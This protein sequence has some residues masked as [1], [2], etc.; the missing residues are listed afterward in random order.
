M[1][2][3]FLSNKLF[4]V[5]CPYPGFVK[6][7]KILLVGNMGLYDYRP[8]VKKVANNKQIMYDCEKGYVLAEGPPGA[9]CIGGQWSPQELPK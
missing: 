3:T 4:S 6:N 9:T 2:N 7:G 5:F 8:Y 1:V